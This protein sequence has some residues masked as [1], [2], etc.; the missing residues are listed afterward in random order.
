MTRIRW[1]SLAGAA[2]IVA[3]VVVRHPP[4]AASQ[5]DLPLIRTSVSGILQAVDPTLN[6]LIMKSDAGE[7][8]GWEFAPAVI[9][10]AGK[11]KP[12]A[13]MWVIYRQAGPSD[14]AVTAIAFPGAEAR[15]VYVNGTGS[16]VRLRLGPAVDAKCGGPS[17][18][19]AAEFPLPPLGS[20]EDPA[21]CW[22]CAGSNET[23]TPANR[24]GAG[25]TILA[26]CFGDDGL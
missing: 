13:R 16:H 24:S 1:G 14:R 20:I 22:C 8:L 23:C 10:E 11:F 25:R 4:P 21:A 3:A 12:G 6:G 7:R 5:A 26:Q 15:P 17:A 18:A 19:V 9:A 2:V